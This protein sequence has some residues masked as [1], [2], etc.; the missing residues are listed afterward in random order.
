LVLRE[1]TTVPEAGSLFLAFE[2]AGKTLENTA[3]T[4]ILRQLL[5][6]VPRAVQPKSTGL[7]ITESS[8]PATSRFSFLKPLEMVKLMNS[9]DLKVAPAVGKALSAIAKAV[10]LIE[11]RMK[12]GG[13][14]IYVGAG[15]SGR[16]GVLDASEI[17]PTFGLPPH[18]VLGIIAGGPKALTQAVEGAEDQLDR[19]MAEIR[20][21]KVG[22]Q[23]TVVGLSVSGKAAFVLGAVGEAS[24]RRAATIGITCNPGSAL[25][26][27]VDLP[28]EV[29]VGPE[30][31]TG[32]SR[33]KAG[34]A[35]KMVLNMLTTCAMAR[36]GFVT[37]NLMTRVAATNQKL[38]DRAARITAEVLN[39]SE[40]QAKKRLEKAGWQIQKVL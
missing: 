7:P 16:L 37:G 32:S 38:R 8:N 31:I 39:I 3:K 34:T 24:R 27:A 25:S 13:R 9:E 30:V 17:P 2:Q 11:K 29:W 4:E 40:D 23:D 10:A 36:L 21:I 26:K 35:Q 22:P 1:D 20:K 15:T 18:R 28:I 33:L 19:G 5:R 12:K 14:L 6:S